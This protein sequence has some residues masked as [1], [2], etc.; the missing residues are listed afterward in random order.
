MS[1]HIETNSNDAIA[2]QVLDIVADKTGYPADMLD[3]E[4]DLEAEL[5]IDSIKQVEILSALKEA[6][7]NLT[8]IDPSSL[9][10][11]RTISEIATAVGSPSVSTTAPET[12]EPD[13]VQ[14]K[15]VFSREVMVD[16]IDARAFEQLAAGKALFRQTVSVEATCSVLNPKYLTINSTNRIEITKHATGFAEQLA[17][18][19]E[20]YGLNTRLVD[21]PSDAAET[22]IVTAGV[23]PNRS[24]YEMLNAALASA[25]RIAIP[26]SK[27][28]G[29]CIFLQS[30][31]GK[32]GQNQREFSIVERG[33]VAALAKTASHEWQPSTVRVI[34]I[35][36]SALPMQQQVASVGMEI[37]FGGDTL[38]VGLTSDGQ[39]WSPTVTA[40]PYEGIGISLED[41]DGVVVTGGGRGI[42]AAVAIR[43]ARE[44]RFNFLLLGRTVLQAWPQDLDR[45]LSL[46]ELR[47]ELSQRAKAEGRPLSLKDL[48]ALSDVLTAS[49]E[50]EDTIAAIRKVGSDAIYRAVDIMDNEK[51]KNEIR[52]FRRESGKVSGIIH[53]AG[54]NHDKLIKDKTP[55][56]LAKVYQPKIEGFK[57][58]WSA[59]VA[60][61]MKFAVMFSSIAG[62][63]GNPGQADYGMAN[64]VLSRFAF[65]LQDRHPKMRVVAMD[66]GPWTGGMVTET[67]K[68]QFESRG[69]PLIPVEIG[70][71]AMVYELVAGGTI[72]P[73]IVFAGFPQA[74][75]PD[76]KLRKTDN[77]S[78]SK[79]AE[80][81]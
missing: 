8:E 69:I 32:F 56:Q 25:K 67:V 58:L 35:D 28:F 80:V 73:E 33:G 29:C 53:G 59:S 79:G 43:L 1:D 55:D 13:E 4:M 65:A 38:E 51:L 9:V 81:A 46:K 22:V 78:T 39:R 5:G 17:H 49:R 42:S 31:G 24:A 26:M 3:V 61:E 77:A 66:W 64:E 75:P 60:D 44:A 19:F 16:K 36:I 12:S 15:Q 68:R 76:P 57:S 45:S 14:P 63:Y 30:T 62:R 10:E 70:V 2:N 37:L 54:V 23:D 7:P 11:L 20:R 50:V 71:E 48:A 72:N 34:D 40:Q 18:F 52:A 6:M 27:R 74:I 21:E 47:L 41:G